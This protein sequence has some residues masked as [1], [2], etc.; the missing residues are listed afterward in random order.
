MS[1]KQQ[2]QL[3]YQLFYQL[4]FGKHFTSL[5]VTLDGYLDVVFWL[6]TKMIDKETITSYTLFSYLCIKSHFLYPFFPLL[7][8]SSPP[9][10]SF[11][12][13]NPSAWNLKLLAK[14]VHHHHLHSQVFTSKISLSLP[15][16]QLLEVMKTPSVLPSGSVFYPKLWII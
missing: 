12:D 4:K 10:H 7:P 14:P 1:A 9:F 15:K 16:S 5:V 8:F 2:I 3:S 11:V 6:F 13:K